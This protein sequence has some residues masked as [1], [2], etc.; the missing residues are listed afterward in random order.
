MCIRDS[1]SPSRHPL[2]AI[3]AKPLLAKAMGRVASTTG[4]VQHVPYELVPCGPLRPAP[5]G[6]QTLS[7]LAAD[8][9]WCG[10]QLCPNVAAKHS[11]SAAFRHLGLCATKPQHAWSSSVWPPG[12][13]A[14]PRQATPHPKSQRLGLALHHR[15]VACSQ[16]APH[17]PQPC[18]ATF[19]P[20][21]GPC[22]H[23]LHPLLLLDVPP[24]GSAPLNVDT[25]WSRNAAF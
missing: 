23:T 21:N 13:A 18:H 16:V 7:G 4:G 19:G 5:R 3:K 15:S 12:Q 1:T 25:C 11:A 14:S 24:H 9:H 10:P 20:K 22:Q 6:R 2:P 17:S 8:G